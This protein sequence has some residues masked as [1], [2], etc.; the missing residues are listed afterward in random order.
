MFR[1]DTCFLLRCYMSTYL[2]HKLKGL[3]LY[4]YMYLEVSLKNQLGNFRV[5]PGTPANVSSKDAI[6]GAF[7]S[8]VI[9][10][11][12][13]DYSIEFQILLK[14]LFQKL[15]LKC[16]QRFPQVLLHPFRDFL[17]HSFGDSS[18]KISTCLEIPPR[19]SPTHNT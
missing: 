5:S 14:K 9:G 17:G 19:H 2:Y 7:S 8:Q 3:C 1:H 11:T 13:R 6:P 15:L 12:F 10:D 16:L 4:S 18:K